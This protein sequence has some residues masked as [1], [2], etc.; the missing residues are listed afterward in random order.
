[1]STW[2][3]ERALIEHGLISDEAPPLP[4][5]SG[6][7]P[8]FVSLVLGAS[9]WLASIFLLFFAFI[10][11]Q[12]D[13]VVGA[14]TLGAVMLGAGFA[15]YAADR[16]D[17]FFE[18][19][20][21]ALSLAG[22]LG[23]LSAVGQATESAVGVA[24]FA[25]LLSAALAVWLPNHFARLLSA[26]FACIA[27]ALVVRLGWWGENLFGQGQL[28]V[29]VGP[30]LV[31]WIVIWVPIAAGVHV[32]IDREPRWMATDSRRVARPALTGL[33]AALSIGTWASEPFAALPFAP[34]PTDIP[35]NW[36]V[37]WPLLGVLAALY[38]ALSAFRLR[39]RPLI[40]LA[41]AGA[42]LHLVQFYYLLG[43]S[44]VAKSVLMIVLGALGL[45][46]ARTLRR[47][48]AAPGSAGGVGP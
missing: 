19:F 5:G 31:G 40:G 43:V 36:L 14:G 32:L 33:L 24:V 17:A 48:G 8:W 15:L 30:A 13:G 1:M 46:A 20:A 44:L 28:A 29:S 35:V 21:L 3:F 39:H 18:Q 34:P 41:I 7:R 45:G 26:F 9:G 12:P 27:W 22:Q 2:D 10:F 16:D 11:F 25:T 42:L 23:L 38:A 4:L 47:R 37:V 6:D